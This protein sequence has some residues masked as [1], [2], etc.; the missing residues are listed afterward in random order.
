M[1]TPPAPLFK[2]QSLDEILARGRIVLELG[3]GGRKADTAAIGVDALDYPG[4]D[5]IGDVFAS[6]ALFPDG[7][8]D[9]VKSSHFVEHIEAF[10]EL[11]KE[12][13]RVLKIG[14]KIDFIAP[15]FSNPYYYS[16][17]THRRFFGLYSFCYFCEESPFS[18]KIPTYDL[19]GSLAIERVDLHF[20]STKPFY[21][22]HA[23]KRLH[24]LIFNSCTYMQEFY[25]ENF[26]YFFP[27]YEVRYRLVRVAAG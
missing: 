9:E 5:I 26:C 18:R 2:T 24:Q 21:I 1:S 11:V 4:V 8:V 23:W 10:P 6:L 25:E 20:K 7:S 15:H 13:V 19:A 22:R 14:G 17:V 12:L 3:C 16:D 27:C